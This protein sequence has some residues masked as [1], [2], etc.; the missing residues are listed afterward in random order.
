[1]ILCP[2][3][4]SSVKKS[5]VIKKKVMTKSGKRITSYQGYRC[6]NGHYF[7]I[8]RNSA[9]AD[10]FVETVVYIYLRCLSLNTTV[11]IIRMFYEEDV[12]SKGQVLDFI[13]IVADKLPTLDD[14][15]GV[16][17]PRRSGFIALD[18]VWFS[19]NKEQIV[20]L[21]C[22]DPISFDVIAAHFEKDETGEGYERLLTNAISKLGALEIKGAYGD[23]DNGLISSLK[24]LLP[25]VPFQL[26]VVHKEMRMGQFVPI[27]SLHL[28]R[29]FTPQQKHEIKE[30]QFLFREVIYALTKDESFKALKRLRAYIKFNPNKRFIKAYNSLERNFAYTL[31]H[32]DHPHMER[33]NNLL[34][35]FNG[36]IKPRLNLMKSF[37]KQENLD[38]YLKLFLLEFRF[39]PLKESRFKERRGQSPLQLGD[40]FLPDS[41]NFITFLRRSFNFK[42]F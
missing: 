5:G 18:G 37:K 36:I 15:D 12:L 28:S 19:F 32:F 1:M 42:F 21:V 3:C 8:G 24:K 40:V 35:C 14:I 7:T 39:R 20:L 4:D 34:E 33:D 30:F 11:D 27:K 41:Y 9:F 16:Y 29:H 25:H 22:F 23:G 6:S 38:R 13:E 26:C 10:S 31:T 2:K 17:T